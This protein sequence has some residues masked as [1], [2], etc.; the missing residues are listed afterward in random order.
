MKT[1][2]Q[3]EADI[4]EAIIKFEREYMGRGMI[5]DDEIGLDSDIVSI[6]YGG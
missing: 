2:G 4:S 3:L 5:G 1:K 6:A